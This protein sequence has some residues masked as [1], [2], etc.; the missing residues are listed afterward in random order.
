FSIVSA[1]P[2]EP[3]IRASG[4]QVNLEASL[5]ASSSV[6][7]WRTAGSAKINFGQGVTA[8][9][10]GASAAPATARALVDEAGT[11][12][13]AVASCPLMQPHVLEASC[14]ATSG[15]MQSSSMLMSTGNGPQGWSCV[16]TGFM[17]N[18]VDVVVPAG[19]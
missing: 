4:G 9:Y 13:V 19:T 12:A 3:A 16:W 8:T 1:L 15:A 5:V 6:L 7:P 17:A 18:A 14:T 10:A 2:A 11:G